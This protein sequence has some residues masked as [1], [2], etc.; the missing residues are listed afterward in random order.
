MKPKYL[1]GHRDEIVTEAIECACGSHVIKLTSWTD[2]YESK[3]EEG[4]DGEFF[5]QDIYLSIFKLENMSNDSIWRR[6]GVAWRYLRSG[7][8]HD[9]QV[10]LARE[11]AEK[12]VNFYQ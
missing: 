5:H 3:N 1:N 10:I 4:H 11:D 7:K 8:M 2:F 9:D 12:L 6:I